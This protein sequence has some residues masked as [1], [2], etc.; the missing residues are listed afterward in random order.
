MT[1]TDYSLDSRMRHADFLVVAKDYKALEIEA[2][3]MKQIDKINPRILRYL[4]YSAYYNDNVDVAIKSLQDY[5]SIPTNNVIS[6]DY[7]YL[8]LSYIKK[9]LVLM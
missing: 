4:G 3:K 5:T 8:G 7:L 1:L 9:L 6:L 2:E